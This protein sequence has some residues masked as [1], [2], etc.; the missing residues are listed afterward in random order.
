VTLL[1]SHHTTPTA[2]STTRRAEVW[3]KRLL[4][5]GN[6]II[7]GLIFFLY[8][9]IPILSIGAGPPVP[10]AIG[11]FESPR[12]Y[13]GRLLFPLSYAG[14]GI[15]L[16]RFGMMP[17]HAE[18]SIG[19]LVVLWSAQVTVGKLMDGLDALVLLM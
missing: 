5:Y 11:T 6:I 1:L 9:S 17:E 8:Y 7:A 14:M 4:N 2:Y 18:V 12:A 3:Q 13:T 15:R 19:A 16:S 10:N